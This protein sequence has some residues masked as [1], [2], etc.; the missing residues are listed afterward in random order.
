MTE[1][2]PNKSGE[3]LIQGPNLTPGYVGTSAAESSAAVIDGYFKTGD[4]GYIDE[5]GYV[6]LVGR[7]KELIKVKG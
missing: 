4:I 5:N 6:F 2:E 7:S 3:H 1:C